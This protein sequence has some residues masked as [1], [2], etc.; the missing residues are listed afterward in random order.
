MILPFLAFAW[1]WLA[2]FAMVLGM[3]GTENAAPRPFGGRKLWPWFAVTAIGLHAGA[4]IWVAYQLGAL[5]MHFLAAI[6]LVTLGMAA[7]TLLLIREGKMANAGLITFPLASLAVL[8]YQLAGHPASSQIDSWPLVLHAWIALL[9]A[10]TLAV[11]AIFAVMLWLQERALQKR[12]WHH[13][14][15][16][17]P[18]LVT[19]ETMLFRSIKLGFALLTLTLL[20]GIVFVSDLF[21]QHLAHKTILSI[22][23]WLIFG[24]LLLGRWKYGWRGTRAAKWTLVAFAILFL[25]F[26]GAGYAMEY[27]LKT[28]P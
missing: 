27:V 25:S 20:T 24:A 9:S 8:G 5:D 2:T 14:L 7:M 22:I 26:F 1:Y 3:H 18:P 15:M 13:T 4:H 6:S 11:S 12:Q 28:K 10:A 21:A 16:S 23:S 17:L 19:I